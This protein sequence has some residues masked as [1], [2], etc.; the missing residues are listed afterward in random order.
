MATE[1]SRK[2]RGDARGVQHNLRADEASQVQGQRPSNVM[3]RAKH[4]GPTASNDEQP[5][6]RPATTGT[7]GGG[8]GAPD[9]DELKRDPEDQSERSDTRTETDDR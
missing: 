8:L 1:K 5:A 6:P 3:Q 4:D 7:P 2:N 9:E